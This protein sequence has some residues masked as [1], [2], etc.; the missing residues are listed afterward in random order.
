MEPHSP[1]SVGTR[2]QW[3]CCIGLQTLL[4]SNVTALCCGDMCCQRQVHDRELILRENLWTHT[5][6]GK[7]EAAYYCRNPI[8]NGTCTFRYSPNPEV[9]QICGKEGPLDPVGHASP[10]HPK[11]VS[12]FL[13]WTREQN[14]H[15]TLPLPASSSVS[16]ESGFG[17]RVGPCL[18]GSSSYRSQV[19]D[20]ALVSSQHRFTPDHKSTRHVG[21]RNLE[22]WMSWPRGL[23]SAYS[24]HWCY[25]GSLLKFS[26]T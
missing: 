2:S 24:A 9:P 12:Y 26:H 11:R 20:S 5:C 21:L 15:L 25:G 18:R 10:T 22:E 7:Q 19:P 23:Q 14:K 6:L 1:P 4:C 17:P 8:R 16:S 13:T 3:P